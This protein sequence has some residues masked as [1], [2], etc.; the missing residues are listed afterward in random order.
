MI[1]NEN[2]QWDPTVTDSMTPSLVGFGASHAGSAVARA[3]ANKIR[4]YASLGRA[5]YFSPFAFETLGGPGPLTATLI[6]CVGKALVRVTGD[7]RAAEFFSQRLSLE[8]QRGNAAAVM[9]TMREWSDP[10]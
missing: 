2:N 7:R 5:Y 4:K 10:G 6:S 9:G 3:E 8:I 1:Q